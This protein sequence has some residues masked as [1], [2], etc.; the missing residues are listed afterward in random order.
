MRKRW[1]GGISLRRRK[2]RKNKQRRES[3]FNEMR[4]KKI[5]MEGEREV[6]RNTK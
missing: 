1:K 6:N 5:G 2:K 4:K 3:K